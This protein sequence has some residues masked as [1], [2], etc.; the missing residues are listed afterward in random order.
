[1]PQLEFGPFLPDVPPIG[2]P[3]LLQARNVIPHAKGYGPFKSPSDAGFGP[4][5]ARP[6][7]FISGRD[8]SGISFLHAGTSDKL[9]RVASNVWTDASRTLGY[10]P[11]TTDLQRWS[12]AQ[13]G[14]NVIATNYF[15]EPQYF[16]LPTGEAGLYD[17]IPVG[18]DR[19]PP[20]A[21]TVGVVKQFLVFGDL[22]DSLNTADGVVPERVHW[23]AINQPLY[24]PFAGSDD[25]KAVQSDFQDLR[26]G[27]GPV[28]R[29]VGASEIGLVFQERRIVRMDYV[30]GPSIFDFR[31]VETDRGTIAPDSVVL[32]GRTVFYLSD[33]GFWATDGTS[34]RPIGLERVNRFFFD[35]VDSTKLTRI[36]A[37]ADPDRLIVVWIYPQNGS[38]FPNRGLIY[39]WGLDKWAELH[40]DLELM[41]QQGTLP[42]QPSLDE[43]DPAQDPPPPDGIDDPVIHGISWDLL[44]S[45]VTDFELAAFNAAFELVS[46]AGKPLDATLETG[47]FELAPGRRSV[48][49]RT[50]PIT[51]GCDTTVAVAGRA[52]EKDLPVYGADQLVNRV[53]SVDARSSGR[54]HRAR[55]TIKN[56]EFTSAFHGIDVMF[57]GEGVY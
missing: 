44:T 53:G 7:G 55:L 42:L 23:S 41:T 32:S 49:R 25:A 5:E 2:N 30:G 50:R 28:Q 35:D 14:N 33:D 29:I 48:V 3:G 15:N 47:D 8:S 11:L 20:Q 27:G 34:S 43:L 13:F 19:A 56:V 31:Q 45:G 18:A 40:L 38:D 39:H 17:N 22:N 16:P 46:F 9:W 36:S 6:R 4:L 26:E 24:W 51:T 37:G 1:M 21:R 52:R 54:Y 10:T 57:Q 12:F